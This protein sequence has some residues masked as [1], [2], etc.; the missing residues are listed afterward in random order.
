VPL[1]LPTTGDF[2]RFL[3]LFSLLIL[4]RHHA[5][6]LRHATLPCTLPS[7]P[8]LCLALPPYSAYPVPVPLSAA[9]YTHLHLPTYRRHAARRTGSQAGG[10]LPILQRK[11]YTYAWISFLHAWLPSGIPAPSSSPTTRRFLPDVLENCLCVLYMPV[12]AIAFIISTA[13]CIQQ[14]PI[15]TPTIPSLLAALRFCADYR[16][17]HSGAA[18]RF[19]YAVVST[20]IKHSFFGYAL[21][22]LSPAHGVPYTHFRIPPGHT[23]DALPGTQ[24]VEGLRTSFEAAFSPVRTLPPATRCT[25]T[26][27]SAYLP[28]LPRTCH[29]HYCGDG[30][31]LATIVFGWFVV[32]ASPLYCNTPLP[33]CVRFR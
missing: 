21:P 9:H 18:L 33:F 3:C 4:H 24:G 16:M 23:M 7:H 19:L 1:L 27:T 26:A 14:E 12:F 28:F 10:L 31:S 5:L 29:F 8:L 17:R 32:A 20:G 30:G 13:C 22:S 25:L 15:P 6:L 2:R 11:T